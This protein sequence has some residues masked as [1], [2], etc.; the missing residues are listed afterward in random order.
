[1]SHIFLRTLSLAV[2]VAATATATI[3]CTVSSTST[4]YADF[5]DGKSRTLAGDVESTGIGSKEECAATCHLLGSPMAGV[6]FGTECHCGTGFNP[7]VA[8]KV[9]PASKCAMPCGGKSESKSKRESASKSL[10]ETCGGTDAVEV[11]N[12]TCTGTATPNYQGCLTALAK[13]QPYCDT[14]LSIDARLDSMFENL[15][16]AETIAMVSPQPSLGSDTC[17][18]HTGGS[19]PIGLGDYYW[20][21]EANTNIAAKCFPGKEGACPTTFVGPL[22]MGASFN[23]TSWNLKG[24]VLGTE[25]RA[26]N[27][28]AWHRGNTE[29]K[30]GLTGFGPNINLARDPRFGRTSEL[31]GEDPFHLGHYAAHMVRGMQEEDAAG[32][33]KMLTYLKHF[34][35]YSTETNRGHD[36]YAIS[37]FD[38]HDSYLAQYKI[39]FEEG[40]A[41]G[42]MCSYDAIN[43]RPSCANGALLND[44][45]RGEWGQEHAFVTTDCG[46]VS[47]MLGA[48]AHAPSNEA[49]AAWTI[50]NGTC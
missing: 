2:L 1:M 13:A 49:A 19:T 39:A 25:M 12:F 18:D 11:F 37:P 20:L 22:G 5:V 9:L 23:R 15:T 29:N 16:M 48:P 8:L 4:C 35:A 33:P 43:G 21:V 30:I 40:N 6:E 50:N 47:N 45:I 44:V 46:A 17:G 14:K 38:L 7:A 34:T 10:S 28:L 42:V 3:T 36:T 26:F 31:P 24:G 32:H 27:N 41:S